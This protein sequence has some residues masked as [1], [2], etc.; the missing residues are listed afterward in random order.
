M[1]TLTDLY[2]DLLEKI[3]HVDRL[4]QEL[5]AMRSGHIVPEPVDRQHA[6]SMIRVAERYINSLDE[7]ERNARGIPADDRITQP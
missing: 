4:Q 5:D 3:Q 1:E 7:S 6:E 2:A